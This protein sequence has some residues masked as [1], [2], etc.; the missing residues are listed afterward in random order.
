MKKKLYRSI[1]LLM[2]AAM[3]LTAQVI[4]AAAAEL[5]PGSREGTASDS[6]EEL[7]ITA[8]NVGK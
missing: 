4:M 3:L 2:L 7:T 5:K 8:I 6:K 1:F